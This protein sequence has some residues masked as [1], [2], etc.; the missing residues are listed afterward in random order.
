MRL[1][2]VTL[3][4]RVGT[5]HR[6]YSQGGAFC[7]SR[8]GVSIASERDIA[9]AAAHMFCEKCFSNGKPAGEAA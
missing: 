3:R 2:I 8:M 9:A 7:N 6:G 5:Y 1:P 4:S